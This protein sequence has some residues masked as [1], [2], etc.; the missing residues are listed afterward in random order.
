[1]AELRALHPVAARGR[2]GRAVVS[3]QV[4]LDTRLDGCRVTSETPAGQGF[5]AAG[6]AAAQ[7]YYRFSPQ[8]RGGR[9]EVSDIVI[10]VE[11]GR[12]TR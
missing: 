10:M 12:P 2:S 8:V 4:Q 9:E 1:V 6:I 7:R 3:C 11:F 5:G